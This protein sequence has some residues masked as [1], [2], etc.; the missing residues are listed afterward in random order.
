MDGMEEARWVDQI[1]QRGTTVIEAA[2]FKTW[3][4]KDMSELFWTHLGIYV[5]EPN[6]E[7]ARLMICALDWAVHA[8]HGLFNSFTHALKWAKIS[9]LRIQYSEMLEMEKENGSKHQ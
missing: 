2:D 8:D 6:K 3:K 9:D 4:M 5:K 1:R 7:S